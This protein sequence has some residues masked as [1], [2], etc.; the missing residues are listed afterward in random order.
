M[1]EKKVLIGWIGVLLMAIVVLCSLPAFAV[2]GDTTKPL[3]GWNE[4]MLNFILPIAV[5]FLVSLFAKAS[6][7]TEIKR[8]ILAALCIAAT[9][10]VGWFGGFIVKTDI[11]VVNVVAT[12]AIVFGVANVLYQLLAKQVFAPI[13]K[14]VGNTDEKKVSPV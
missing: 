9:G 14:S 2:T 12:F 13:T 11:S 10:A 7:S 3:F 5:P 4:Q 6:W 8:G 1:F